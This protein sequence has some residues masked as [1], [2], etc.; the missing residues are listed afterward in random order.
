[1]KVHVQLNLGNETPLPL[2]TMNFDPDQP[3]A[4]DGKWSDSGGG[5][6]GGVKEAKMGSGSN[7]S[8]PNPETP[9]LSGAL[10]GGKRKLSLKEASEKLHNVFGKIV[11]TWSDRQIRENIKD[12]KKF[13]IGSDKGKGENAVNTIKIKIMEDVLRSRG[14]KVPR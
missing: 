12:I 6:G 13:G 2:P 14:V 8:R 7:E 5:G 3:R 1:M 10:V 9:W 11:K 4:D